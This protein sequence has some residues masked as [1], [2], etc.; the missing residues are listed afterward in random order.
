MTITVSL[1]DLEPGERPPDKCP[2]CGAD[3]VRHPQPVPLTVAACGGFGHPYDCVRVMYSC[4][5]EYVWFFN[6]KGEA[7]YKPSHPCG[8]L[9]HHN[10]DYQPPTPAVISAMLARGDK[11]SAILE[12]FG[13]AVGWNRNELGSLLDQLEEREDDSAS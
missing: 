6:A 3:R 1:P 2:H 4:H 7:W 11:P 5:A 13:S 10:R 12:A 8:N 9:S